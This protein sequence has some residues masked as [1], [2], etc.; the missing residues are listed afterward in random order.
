MSECAFL[1][2]QAAE[3]RAA[4]AGAACDWSRS[5]SVA[6]SPR[7]WVSEHPFATLG[8]PT[9]GLGGVAA[10]MSFLFLRKK[11]QH[12][13]GWLSRMFGR[14]SEPPPQSRKRKVW[15]WMILEQAFAMAQPALFRVITSLLGS[16]IPHHGDQQTSNGGQVR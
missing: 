9:L 14:E 1:A 10:M 6:L 2:E 12:A 4:M 16:L 5:A 8:I 11:K 3:A 15:W 7:Q 13:G